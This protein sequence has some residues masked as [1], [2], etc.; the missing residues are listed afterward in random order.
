MRDPYFGHRDPETGEEMSDR[1]AWTSWDFALVSA[2]QII[3]D[4]TDQDGILVW[5]NDA[6]N[7]EVLAERK[8]SKFDASRDAKTS[9]KNYKPRPGERFV[10]KVKKT[11]GEYPT[12]SEWVQKQIEEDAVVE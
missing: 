4:H 3:Q 8:I 9:G 2:Y 5:D 1:E 11:Y 12:Y 6:D 10:P 7:I